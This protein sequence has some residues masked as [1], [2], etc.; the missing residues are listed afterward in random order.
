MPPRE[1]KTERNRR[2]ILQGS[3]LWGIARFGV[4]LALGMI[5]HTSFN[6]IDLFMISRLENGSVALAAL[7]LCD[8]LAAIATILSSGVSTAT[9][10]LI[11]RYL[12]A[13]QLTKLR[14]T[15]WQSLLLVT[16]MSVFFGFVGVFGSEWLIFDVLKTQGQAAKLAVPYLQISLGGCFSIF[17][18]VQL[19]AILRAL[20]HAKTA[21]SLLVGGNG[22][23]IVL[24]V[25]LIYGSGP[26]PE[27]FAWGEAIAEALGIPRMGLLGAAW[28][29]VI[30]RTV[31]VLIG[32][33]ILL[34]R[35]AGP[36]FHMMYMRPLRE[37]LLKLW[38]LAW[39]AGAQL[40]VRVCAVLFVLALLNQAYTSEDDQTVLTAFS[41]CLRLETMVL[42][43]GMGW[44]A[45]ASSFVGT[46]LGAG[47]HSRASQSG[48]IA[49]GLNLLM[50][51][52]LSMV[53]LVWAPSIIRFFDADQRV[54]AVG[55]EYI[56]AVALTYGFLGGTIVL[57][58]AMAGAGATLE[59]LILDGIVL[60]LLVVP[61]A[62]IV[63]SI[64]DL[65]REVL[66]KVLAWGNI[67]GA[68]IY[69]GYYFRGRFLHKTIE[70][71]SPQ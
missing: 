69:G 21:A 28:A 37:E 38:R 41:V 50:M 32:M 14:R 45:A 68:L 7:G 40:V 9:V 57:S 1:T 25:L 5:L 63:V 12:G 11:S 70:Y 8:M 19:V 49:A 53:Y 43:V 48:W 2:R 16:I 46:C 47:D 18:L 4:P 62:F 51:L 59:I 67:V 15:T 65:P 34:R 58:Q 64:L 35:K 10:A 39:P 6:L 22:L 42:F 31:P 3:L 56:Q 30:A 52:T 55:V 54:V 20:G 24:N 36:R 60:G 71:S 17:F 27:A 66:W 33:M 29:T 23:N 13:N 26:A 44:G 61:A